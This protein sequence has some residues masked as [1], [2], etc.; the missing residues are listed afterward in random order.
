MPRVSRVQVLD[1]LLVHHGDTGNQ[2]MEVTDPDTGDPMDLAA[3]DYQLS[4]SRNL[5]VAI[6]DAPLFTV[7]G[8]NL[9]TT[10]RVG[11]AIS[12]PNWTLIVDNDFDSKGL[13]YFYYDVQRKDAG[14]STGKKTLGRGR[15]IVEIEY[16][17]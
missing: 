14:L 7:T 3:Y 12:D 4:V 5:N 2:E 16:T 8:T 11:F 1:D 6:A 17:P 10:G 13:A 9:T 15:F